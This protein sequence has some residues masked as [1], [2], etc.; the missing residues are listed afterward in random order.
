[1]LLNTQRL[2][3]FRFIKLFLGKRG[4]NFSENFLRDTHPN[5]PSGLYLQ[6]LTSFSFAAYSMKNVHY[7]PAKRIKSVRTCSLR[8]LYWVSTKR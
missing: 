7:T 5:P 4:E 8:Y 6:R 3:T 1:M 2:T